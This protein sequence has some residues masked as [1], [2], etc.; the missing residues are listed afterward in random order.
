M[1]NT[2]CKV[3]KYD[4]STKSNLTKHTNKFKGKCNEKK[5]YICKY[6]DKKL[7][8]SSS[9]NRHEKKCNKNPANK[10]VLRGL[11]NENLDMLDNKTILSILGKGKYAIQLLFKK[12]HCNNKVP[13]NHNVIIDYSASDYV[14]YYN[15]KK[16]LMM[17]KDDFIENQHNW[18]K[19][20]L[21]K[22]VDKFESKKL[23]GYDEVKKFNQFITDW[24]IDS[25]SLK[26][27]KK[28]NKQMIS[29]L[30]RFSNSL[31]QESDTESDSSSSSEDEIEYNKEQKSNF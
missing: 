10:I 11:Y 4:F 19:I 3:C 1:T 20:M 25:N 6:C 8:N 27:E 15:G 30:S 31:N 23:S 13:E 12:I 28:I 5:K 17:M 2:I 29:I 9:L 21:F 7:C 22:Y 14:H 18:I 24:N 16:W 26:I